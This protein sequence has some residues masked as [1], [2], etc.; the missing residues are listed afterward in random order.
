MNILDK[1]NKL[2][3]MKI[4]AHL[5]LFE[6]FEHVYLFGS[7]LN[8]DDRYNDIDIL[9]IYKKYSI[10]IGWQLKKITNELHKICRS[11]IDLTALSIEEEKDVAF[12]KRLNSNYLKIK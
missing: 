8:L 4:E 9:V 2:I 5:E 12:L 6:Y 10:E 1:S 7:V 11:T 3:I